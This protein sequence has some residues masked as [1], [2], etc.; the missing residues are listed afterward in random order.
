MP[1]HNKYTIIPELLS[2]TTNL[3]Y[4]Y[5]FPFG[6]PSPVVN[7]ERHVVNLKFFVVEKIEF[8]KSGAEKFNDYY[9][10]NEKL[11]FDHYFLFGKR[12]RAEL[13]RDDNGEFTLNVER[14]YYRYLKVGIESVDPPG[15]LLFDMALYLLMSKGYFPLHCSAFSGKMG[16]YALTA[17]S[18]TGKSYTAFSMAEKHGAKLITEDIALYDLQGNLY[19]CPLMSIHSDYID[20][21]KESPLADY[22]DLLLPRIRKKPDTAHFDRVYGNLFVNGGRLET[23]CLLERGETDRIVPLTDDKD[24]LIK[25]VAINRGEFSYHSSV[26]L[27]AM[28]YFWGEEVQV[29]VMME[30]ECRALATL[31]SLVHK[32]RVSG[33]RYD[34]YYN[35]L[36]A[37]I[38]EAL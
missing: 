36:S 1:N 13:S 27:R 28:E 23:L 35:L 3:D 16:C 24:L 30:K 9:L 10:A 18:N 8:E 26:L 5:Y 31:L 37:C 34:S 4:V 33:T 29:E 21:K 11:Y 14:D 38:S 20:R 17:T 7:S 2:V 12:L 15:R 22:I 19:S 32:Q 6:V 25:L